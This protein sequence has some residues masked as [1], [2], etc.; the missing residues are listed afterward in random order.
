M[1]RAITGGAL[2][3]SSRPTSGSALSSSP[4]APRTRASSTTSPP[5]SR[6]RTATAPGCTWT[7]RTGC[8][9]A[10]PSVRERFAGI[11]RADSFIVDPLAVRALRLLRAAVPGPAPGRRRPFP[12]RRLSRL[13][14]PRRV[15]PLG[16]GRPP[17][18][19]H[20]RAAAVVLAGHARH[21]R[22]HRRDRAVPEQLPHRGPGDRGGRA[23]RAAGRAG[24]VGG[25]VPPPGLDPCRLSAL[26]AAPGQGRHAP[27]RAH[28]LPRRGRAAA[29]LRE[30]VDGPAG[31]DRGAAHHDAGGRRRWRPARGPARVTDAEGLLRAARGGLL[32][33]PQ[34][35]PARGGAVRP[36]A[37]R[38]SGR[39]GQQVAWRSSDRR[40]SSGRG[41][42]PGRH[43]VDRLHRLAPAA[44]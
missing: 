23:S 6:R 10:A 29:R 15:E 3:T 20:P 33:R 18:P 5:W 41:A 14:R 32:V 1:I 40:P 7:V 21:R 28:R 2:S 12:A 24:A 39:V 35:L 44:S 27:V 42:V 25:G 17:L 30:P 36:S 13:D 11:E 31:R 16:P 26:V 19:P 8:G 37:P 43:R 9:L 38:R 4:A 34:V 22:V